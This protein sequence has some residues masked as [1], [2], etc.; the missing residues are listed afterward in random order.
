MKLSTLLIGLFIGVAFCADGQ[1]VG[2]GEIG[3]WQL[4]QI[5]R[6]LRAYQLAHPWQNTSVAPIGLSAGIAAGWNQKIFAP[7]GLHAL[8]LIHYRH[9]T[10][11][12][13]S[14]S[15]PLKAGFHSTGIEIL[16]RSHPR[17]LVQ[18]VQETG[19]LGTR[20]YIQLGTIYNWNLPFVKKYGERVTIG[21]NQPYRNITSQLGIS[22]G[23][24]FHAFNIGSS[25][26]TFETNLT[27]FPQFE[28][29]QFATAVLGHNEARLP[30]MDRNCFLL[31]GHIRVTIQKK[32]NNWWDAPRRG[33]KS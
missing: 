19:P 29:D 12:W 25:I 22:G 33:D 7:R 3:Y 11:S 13:N 9:Q 6:V 20:W 24:G 31:Q 2:Q 16:I 17:C 4:P 8:G 18:D 26:F 32:N 30:S 28:L 10:T 23:T 14:A 5:N 21:N 15:I 1:L 27:W